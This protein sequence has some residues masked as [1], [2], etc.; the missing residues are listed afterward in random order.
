MTH[1][2]G[3]KIII[4][5]SDNDL[6]PGRRQAMIWTNAGILV[7]IPLGINFREDLIKINIFSFKKMHAKLSSAKWHLFRLGHNE[8]NI[9]LQ[10]NT[11][12]QNANRRHTLFRS[13]VQSRQGRPWNKKICIHVIR[14][15]SKYYRLLLYHVQP[16]LKILCNTKTYTKN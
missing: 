7:I 2:C 14:N 13:V 5:G 11:H 4:T 12:T 3:S 15:I 16:I 6:S 10:N 9:G 8:L 1:I